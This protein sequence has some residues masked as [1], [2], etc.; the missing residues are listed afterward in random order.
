MF[1]VTYTIASPK[2]SEPKLE[3]N[4]FDTEREGVYWLLSALC[5]EDVNDIVLRA[6]RRDAEAGDLDAAYQALD[7]YTEESYRNDDV[8]FAWRKHWAYERGN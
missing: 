3:V 2:S 4:S 8:L 5:Q 7:E 6:G 1:I